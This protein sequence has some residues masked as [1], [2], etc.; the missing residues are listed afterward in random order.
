MINDSCL[1]INISLSILT[2]KDSMI[3]FDG[4]D[5]LSYIDYLLKY[6]VDDFFYTPPKKIII[7]MLMMKMIF[8]L[9]FSIIYYKFLL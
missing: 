2:L 4:K 7:C 8:D 9:Y 1:S 6:L 3:Y 5:K